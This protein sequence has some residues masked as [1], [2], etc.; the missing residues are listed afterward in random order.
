MVDRHT[1]NYLSEEHTLPVLFQSLS[2]SRKIPICA[3]INIKHRQSCPGWLPAPRRPAAC[4][5]S[6]TRRALCLQN[7]GDYCM[8]KSLW[9]DVAPISRILRLILSAETFLGRRMIFWANQSLFWLG[10]G[11]AEGWD[12]FFFFIIIIYSLF[13]Y[14][15]SQ[16]SL[17]FEQMHTYVF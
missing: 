15:G 3:C 9:G 13:V 5:T 8:L 14:H 2:Q 11:G 16:D 7:R 1:T 4:E 6:R 10:G 17:L 12:F